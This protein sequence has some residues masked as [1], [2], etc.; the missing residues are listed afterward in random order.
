LIQLVEKFQI[1][2]EIYHGDKNCELNQYTY[3]GK[4]LGSSSIMLVFI[5]K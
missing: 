2:K 5:M 1:V 4:L 3:Y